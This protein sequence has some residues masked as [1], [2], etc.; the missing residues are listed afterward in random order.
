MVWYQDE[1]CAALFTSL[2][3]NQTKPDA[4][5]VRATILA[6]LALDLDECSSSPAAAPLS[7]LCQLA[8]DSRMMW[9]GT[10][11]NIV[12]QSFLASIIIK[13]SLLKCRLRL[14][15]QQV[16]PWISTSAVLASPPNVPLAKLQKSRGVF[17]LMQY[18]TV[19]KPVLH[20][21]L[22]SIIIKQTY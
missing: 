22:A 2:K 21:F 16:L 7:H 18:G 15:H 17:R 8:D 11:M 12:Q 13:P 6:S 1:S 9:L 5:W 3:H 10:A 14:R 4:M 20:S 19:M